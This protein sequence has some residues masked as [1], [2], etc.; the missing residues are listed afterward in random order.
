MYLKK[1][2]L[3]TLDTIAVMKAGSIVFGTNLPTSDVD[4]KAIYVPKSQDLL[5]LDVK[6]KINLTTKVNQ[7]EKNTKDDV[8]V[9]IFSVQGYLNQLLAGETTA[10]EMLFT[11][12]E[13][14][15]DYVSNEIWE[16]I[17]INR[18]YFL[19][20]GLT[21]FSGFCLSQAN[22]YSNDSKRVAMMKK[23]LDFFQALDGN[24][25]VRDYEVQVKELLAGLV[26]EN[27]DNKELIGITT[28]PQKNTG[29]NSEY[30][31]VCGRKYDF[32]AKVKMICTQIEGVYQGYLK[33]PE[34]AK[35]NEINWKDLMHAVRVT[36]EA[37]ELLATNKITFPRPNAEVL[38]KI[39]R[40]EF[41]YDEVSEMIQKGLA[42]MEEAAKISELR[43]SP[44]SEAANVI[45]TMAHR[46]K[47]V[48]F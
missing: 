46:Q 7:Y 8:D 29:K 33:R 30:L 14:Y 15:L 37:T 13:M 16:L 35:S 41:S 34:L 26:D 12:K 3:P 27:P 6:N 5:L 48:K 20:S 45:I 23:T 10:V 4:Y 22:K 17:Q 11:P 32:N 28:V 40:G 44:S 39:R 31:E 1:L 42:E 24:N 36:G 38:L 18:D 9:E 21:A 43:K 2:N 25:S 47:I 19:H